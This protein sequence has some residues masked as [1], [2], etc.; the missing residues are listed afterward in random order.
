MS[1]STGLARTE[2]EPRPV[3]LHA[4][5]DCEPDT[6]TRPVPVST[7]T[8]LAPVTGLAPTDPPTGE[9]PREAPAERGP[10]RSEL[11]ALLRAILEAL[12]GR[13]PVE[14]LRHRFSNHCYRIL[15]RQRRDENGQGR[16]RCLNRVHTC[17]PAQGVIELC[18]T[19]RR[20]GR[21]EAVAARIE[22]DHL[23]WRCTAML[24]L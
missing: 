10:S 9:T 5:T 20:S 22:F 16:V 11:H 6:T 21:M 24:L 15:L 19:I 3:R 23:G 4:L 8:S 13:R 2:P 1:A 12:D 7:S 14:Q 17:R 18:A